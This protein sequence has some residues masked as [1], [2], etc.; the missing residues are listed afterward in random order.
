MWNEA[1]YPPEYLRLGDTS[2]AIRMRFRLISVPFPGDL[3]HVGG[4]PK[5][6]RGELL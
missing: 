2:A 1:M 6:R 4:R 3:S 5:R